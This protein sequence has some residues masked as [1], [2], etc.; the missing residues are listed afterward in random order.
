MRS[1]SPAADHPWGEGA[2]LAQA[3]GEGDVA[4]WTALGLTAPPAAWRQALAGL[5][6]LPVAFSGDLT[7]AT[8]RIVCGGA[9]IHRS[10]GRFERLPAS[11]L[12]EVLSVA[13]VGGALRRPAV[14]LLPIAEEIQRAPQRRCDYLALGPRIQVAAARLGAALGVDL[15]AH[16]GSALSPLEGVAVERLYGLFAPFSPSLDRRTY[17]F[18]EP[19]EAEVL[20]TYA[21]YCA[22]YRQIPV[23]SGTLL[24]EGIH[25]SASVMIGRRA[26]SAFLATTPMPA[27]G[28][29]QRL[30]V[31]CGAVPDLAAPLP[32]DPH[33]WPERLLR[34]AT[35]LGFEDLRRLW[36]SG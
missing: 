2:R 17:P 7:P 5:T 21:S 1:P 26:D 33:G 12:W 20:R 8:T 9:C 24:V 4:A 10:D 13:L 29:S 27:L 16:W 23:A 14:V 6:P 31:D 34:G 36:L 22:R 15:Q 28:E 30:M 11:F 25:V 35:G 3:M 32:Q 18:G 19:D